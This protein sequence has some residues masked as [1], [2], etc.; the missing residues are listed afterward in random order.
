METILFPTDFA[1]S[2]TDALNWVRLFARHYNAL[3][4]L[5]HVQPTAVSNATLPVAGELGMGAG[6]VMDV[7]TESTSRDQLTALADQLRG[8]GLT[9]QIDLRR[10]A[11]KDA[12]LSATGEHNADLIITGR[13]HLNNFFE[14]IAG[15]AATGIARGANCPV[16]VVPTD[17]GY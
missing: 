6:A 14:R 7:N 5:V 3:L 11:V 10:G 15:T 17:G 16:L 1:E 9:C 13:S 2:T 8:E 4:I 12:I